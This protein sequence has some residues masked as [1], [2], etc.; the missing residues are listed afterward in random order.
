M[1]ILKS[2]RL[3]VQEFKGLVDGI[4]TAVFDR[5]LLA[6]QRRVQFI[7]GRFSDICE[8]VPIYSFVSA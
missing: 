4:S 6:A 7:R 5:E 2:K 8:E 3:L 1:E